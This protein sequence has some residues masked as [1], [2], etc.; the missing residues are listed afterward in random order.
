MGEKPGVGGLESSEAGV[1]A[2]KVIW[3]FTVNNGCSGRAN[4]GLGS[5]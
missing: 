3:G 4:K 1:R 2:G 5:R